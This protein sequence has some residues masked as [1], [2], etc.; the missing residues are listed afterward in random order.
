[1]PAGVVLRLVQKNQ[2]LDRVVLAGLDTAQFAWEGLTFTSGSDLIDTIDRLTHTPSGYYYEFSLRQGTN[3]FARMS[4]GPASMETTEF[5]GLWEGQ[6][7]HVSRWASDLA[8][9]IA[10]P[11]LWEMVST[12][13]SMKE[14]PL[15]PEAA[16]PFSATE[17]ADLNERLDVIGAQLANLVTT[18]DLRV[19]A[20]ELVQH[21]RDE[22]RKQSRWNWANLA[23]GSIVTFAA[24]AAFDPH[25]AKEL[26]QILVSGIRSLGSGF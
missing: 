1:M 19:A 8:A 23:V 7:D 5:P 4:P 11:D 18:D 6:L 20:G 24:N 2:V 10:A 9:E 16:T 14:L 13:D 15:G 21:L 3:H 17:I 12:W 26:I 25:R 22:L